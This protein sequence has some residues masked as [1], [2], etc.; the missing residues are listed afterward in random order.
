[1]VPALACDWRNYRYIGV[2]SPE[3]VRTPLLDGHSSGAEPSPLA[4]GAVDG[5]EEAMAARFPLEV[6]PPALTISLCP[7][8][9]HSYRKSLT[10][11]A[12]IDQCVSL[13]PRQGP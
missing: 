2:S 8:M 6:V 1:M 12:R 4:I 9:G 10:P 13:E 3:G 5:D 7:I 11:P